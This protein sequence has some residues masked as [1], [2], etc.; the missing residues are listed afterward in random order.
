V[1]AEGKILN[2]GKTSSAISFE[3]SDVEFAISKK[4]MHRLTWSIPNTKNILIIYL[5]R[6]LQALKFLF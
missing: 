2:S 4:L 6:I 5:N 1:H 3:K